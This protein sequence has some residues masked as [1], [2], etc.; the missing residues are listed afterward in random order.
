MSSP[1]GL[2]AAIPLSVVTAVHEISKRN[3]TT[4][5]AASLQNIPR[6]MHLHPHNRYCTTTTAI[7][8]I[9]TPNLALLQIRSSTHSIPHQMKRRETR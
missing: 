8:S 3:L 1:T 4:T 7:P 2:Q 9:T 5:K 6:G